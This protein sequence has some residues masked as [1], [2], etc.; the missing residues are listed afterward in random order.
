MILVH[1]TRPR[2]AQIQWG[3]FTRSFLVDVWVGFTQV[4]KAFSASSVSFIRSFYYIKPYSKHVYSSRIR[5]GTYE[6][7]CDST[8]LSRQTSE[9]RLS[10]TRR[11]H[12]TRAETARDMQWK[13]LC[14]AAHRAEV[15]ETI[16]GR[17]GLLDPGRISRRRKR[18]KRL[19]HT[20]THLDN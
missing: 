11:D 1:L 3:V 18:V 7:Q 16:A 6:V 13:G 5:S 12:N 15:G 17:T 9:H 10:A 8:F 2:N 14:A 4:A 20:R 19:T